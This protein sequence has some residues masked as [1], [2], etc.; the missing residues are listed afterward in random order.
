LKVFNG[1]T[2]LSIKANTSVMYE[3]LS[4]NIADNYVNMFSLDQIDAN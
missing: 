4:K 1:S 3:P 2:K